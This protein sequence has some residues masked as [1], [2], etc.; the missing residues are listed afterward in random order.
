MDLLE[1]AASLAPDEFMAA[2]AARVRI[3]AFGIRELDAY[4]PDFA[5]L[6]FPEAARRN[7]LALRD[8]QGRLV[9]AYD[10]P[11]S[12]ELAAWADAHFAEPYSWRLVHHGDLVAFLARHE[13]SLSALDTLA[14]K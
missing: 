9:L 14:W 13:E 12:T 5:A 10:D 1:E 2:L 11:F 6:S 7:C 3:P 8:P 4:A